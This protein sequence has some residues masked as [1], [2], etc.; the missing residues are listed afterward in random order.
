[1][2]S[3]EKKTA[4]NYDR[5]GTSPITGTLICPCL[6]THLCSQPQSQSIFSLKNITFYTLGTTSFVMHGHYHQ[7]P[8]AG[9]WWLLWKSELRRGKV[10]HLIHNGR[11]VSEPPVG[12]SVRPRNVLSSSSSHC[13]PLR[14]CGL[15]KKK[16]S[17]SRT[18]T[19]PQLVCIPGQKN[20]PLC[21]GIA[22]TY[23][24]SKHQ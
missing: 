24:L 16:K 14:G 15:L 5:M 9:C 8:C 10:R 3:R 6:N 18:K 19:S 13:P 12:S 1:M 4:V 11:I 17:P 7:H 20:T 23:P 22:F 21:R 2:Q